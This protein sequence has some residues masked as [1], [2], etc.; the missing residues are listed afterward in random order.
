MVAAMITTVTTL[1]VKDSRNRQMV[2]S[3]LRP[4][5][6]TA[7]SEDIVAHACRGRNGKEVRDT[8]LSTALGLPD[9]PPTRPSLQSNSACIVAGPRNEISCPAMAAKPPI[10]HIA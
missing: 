9:N 10:T 5:A 4:E 3:I 7:C 8:Y 6:G 1:T 2:T